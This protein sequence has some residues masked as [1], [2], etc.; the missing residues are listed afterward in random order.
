MILVTG[1]GGV[2]AKVL[3]ASGIG[4]ALSPGLPCY[5]ACPSSC[6]AFVIALALR[7]AQ[8]LGHRGHPH[9]LR[10]AG[11]KHQM[12]GGGTSPLQVALLTVAIGFGGLGLSARERF[13]LLDRHP[14]PGPERGRWPARWTVL[15]TILGSVFL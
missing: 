2:F 14:L 12:A 15:T 4:T 8:G 3:T 6:W 7:A 9:H 5:S 11:R 10:P 13:G 1:A